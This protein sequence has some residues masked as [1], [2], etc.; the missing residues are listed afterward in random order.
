LTLMIVSVSS[1]QTFATKSFAPAPDSDTDAMRRHLSEKPTTFFF[2][3]YF[4]IF[5]CRSSFFQ[6]F[7][8]WCHTQILHFLPKSPC[9][10]YLR[11]IMF[12]ERKLLRA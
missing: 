11:K 10:W 4:V 2:R 8:L 3:F 5:G 9:T 6:A 12:P 1:A 7:E